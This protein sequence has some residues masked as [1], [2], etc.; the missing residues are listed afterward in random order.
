MNGF[1]KDIQYSLRMMRKTPGF[2]AVAVLSLALGIGANTA[3][4]SLI[5]NLM[6]R[7]LPISDPQ[8]LVLLSDP[9][10]SGASIGIQTGDRNLYTY[11][12][13]QALRDH[14]TVL[15]GL[16]AVQAFPEKDDISIGG[17]AGSKEP[18]SIKM[19][20]GNFFSVLG[21]KPAIGRFFAADE[22][23]VTGG[24]P[25]A[26]I[27]YDYWKRR[28]NRSN[29]ILKQTFSL[30]RTSFNIVGVAPPGFF[31]DAVGEA[32]DIWLPVT[33]QPFV[34]P[35]REMLVQKPGVVEK[36][37]WLRLAGRLRPGV[38]AAQAKAGLNVDFR[39]FL[40]A[41]A[42]GSA[43]SQE[44]KRNIADTR[45]EVYSGAR[46]NSSLRAQF[47]EPLV[48]LM[49]LVGL[50]LLIAC[51][52]VA[53]L[54]LA[55][56]TARQ[57]EIAVRLALGAG[58]GRLVRQLMTE[59]IVLSLSG[60]V[61]G[62]IFAFWAAR[63]LLVMASKTDNTIPLD[64]APDFRLLGFAF[65]ISVLTGLIFGVFPALR[66]TRTDVN[67]VLKDNTRGVVAGTAGRSPRFS[68][69]K[70]LVAVQVGL[71][72]LMLVGAG[73][74]ARSLSNL[75]SVRLGY[76]PEHLLMVPLDPTAAGYA[77]PRNLR[78]FE[79]ILDRVHEIPGVRSAS[80]SQNGLFSGSESGDR[81]SVEGYTSSNPRDLSARFD[82][83]GPEY[84][85]TVGIPILLGREFGP[86]D[87]G[88]APRVCVINE[89]MAKFYFGKTNP[90]GKH[91]RDEFPDTRVT[92]EIVGVVADA[93]YLKVRE[94]PLRRFYMPFFNPLGGD[95]SFANI[96]VRTNADPSSV[97]SAIRREILNVDSALAPE[98]GRTV[99][100][101]VDESLVQDRL[102]ARL[103]AVFGLLALVL[104]AI[105]LYGVL[106]YSVA[107]RTAEI[108]IRMA[109]GAARK[110][111]LQLVLRESMIMVIAGVVIG[112]PVAMASARLVESRLFGLKPIDPVTITVACVVLLSVALVAAIIPALR[113]SRIDPIRAL[114]YE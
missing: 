107:R 2:T 113:A 93:K 5:D 35:G 83:V 34:I 92:F 72:L 84:F 112:V 48:V 46:G 32:P 52:N 104:A 20:T 74:F 106:S 111:V 97:V 21:V 57:R 27:S 85:K 1:I 90:I 61:A 65:A 108:G 28:F 13:Y 80:L 54:L 89:T 43:M 50:V 44:T 64:I 40:E 101:R 8:Q 95:T 73:L 33:M 66:V 78:L 88:S 18:A 15:S 12:E 7:M 14:N 11:A 47:R 23:R 53:N 4:F 77:Y 68:V 9:G 58:R 36:V 98:T 109:L 100:Q 30:Y 22:D 19:V 63:L 71:S 62:V 10:T 114:R 59:S 55:R 110:N 69:G 75:T 16:I 3:I 76:E 99:A 45:I 51:A 91:I 38:S 26:V 29:E 49:T 103:S 31:G 42:G 105:G 25:V 24:S 17:G 86:Q 39:R 70:S 102:I 37:M 79:Q 60:G 81:I 56:S 67:P 94:E 41:E 82:Q 87:S 6:L 96:M